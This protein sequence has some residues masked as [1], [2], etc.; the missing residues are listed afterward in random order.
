MDRR[1]AMNDDDV[2]LNCESLNLL[3]MY[4]AISI[5][6]YL[7]DHAE[8][9]GVALTNLQVQSLT[10]M[11][12]GVFAGM[13]GKRLVEEDFVAWPTMP[14]VPALYDRLLRF[15]NGCVHR[16]Q[17]ESNPPEGE[18]SEVIDAVFAKLRTTDPFRL[19]DLLRTLGGP[20]YR[21]IKLCQKAFLVIP[22]ADICEFY[23]A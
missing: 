2:V 10:F 15:G 17:D 18:A 20:W 3:I 23:R 21:T 7:I 12:H 1:L 14:V 8:S 4:K 16:I 9:Q 11:C 13:Y 5:V 6:N 19:V 22:F